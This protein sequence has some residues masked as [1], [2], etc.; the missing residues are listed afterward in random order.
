MALPS[1]NDF[2]NMLEM[3]RLFEDG[4]VQECLKAWRDEENTYDPDAV[5]D[6]AAWLV[7]HGHLTQWQLE[8]IYAG[9]YK[10]FF[11]GQYK[12]LRVIGAGGM[13]SV[14]LAVHTLLQ[15]Q[16]AIKVLPK[17]RVTT[18]SS[19]LERFLLEAQ[20]A[21]AL[22]HPN[23]VCAYD[24]DNEGGSIYYIVME[25]VD[26]KDLLSLVKS[27]GPMDIYKAAN[28]I[29][30]AAIGLGHAHKAGL[31]HRDMKPANL[32]VD[33][34]GVIRILDLGLAR[35]T[36]EKRASLTVTYDENVLGTADYLA[37]EQ[38]RN[39]HTVDARA[40]IYG[41]GCTLYCLLTGHVPFPEG[42]LPQRIWAHQKKMPKR[43]Q[44]ERP[45]VPNDLAAICWRML[46]KDPNDRQQ[47][48]QEVA[49][50]L[51][52]WL[53]DHGQ[54][55][56]GLS[57]SYTRRRAAD[58]S[59][60]FAGELSVFADFV[61]ADAAA[62]KSGDSTKK[63]GD[64]PKK[65]A[66]PMFFGGKSSESGS[67]SDRKKAAQAASSSSSLKKKA[68]EQPKEKTPEE[69]EQESLFLQFLGQKQRFQPAKKEPAQRKSSG[70]SVNSVLNFKTTQTGSGTPGAVRKSGEIK[71][72]KG[73]NPGS[74]SGE[75]ISRP[76]RG[77]SSDI[78]VP[79]KK[80]PEKSAGSA[81]GKMPK[82]IKLTKENWIVIGVTIFLILILAV[83]LWIR[84]PRKKD[85][86]D[87][88]SIPEIRLLA[89][90]WAID[91]LPSGDA[92][93]GTCSGSGR[94]AIENPS[95]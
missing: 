82:G 18:D 45:E 59:E 83:V 37:P 72:G 50:D 25:Y 19:Y 56:D 14:Y 74:G 79:Q 11:L 85:S 24:V 15:R 73:V 12:L 7:K 46:A 76:A 3:S 61:A 48:A 10:G 27:G 91:F 29:R 5:A 65:S 8:N 53:L 69:E 54:K 81:S 51:T 95:R 36:D 77:S 64:E 23:I 84:A 30:Q 21:A 52:D 17:S 60:D 89:D 92:E 28:Y 1:M 88:V 49:D 43:I 40:D 13:S 2:L 31:I 4:Q 26:G 34:R 33:G 57:G 63:M 80:S 32:L 16:V 75:K 20:A 71:P 86:S 68:D 66:F 39:S 62:K 90:Y 67:D 38:A 42:T 70:S 35:F 55:V 58:S 41:L 44:D 78:R 94:D 22:S 87:E 93:I 9:K 6:F 47:T